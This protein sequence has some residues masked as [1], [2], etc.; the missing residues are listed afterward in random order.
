[1]RKERIKLKE[2]Q[3]LGKNLNLKVKEVFGAGVIVRDCR[4]FHRG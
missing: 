2:Y 3:F 1:L 4:I